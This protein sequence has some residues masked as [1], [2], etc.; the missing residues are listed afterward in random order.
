MSATGTEDESGTVREE[1]T[2]GEDKV[3]KGK[4]SSVLPEITVMS[5]QVHTLS[6]LRSQDTVPSS[7]D[8]FDRSFSTRSSVGESSPFRKFNISLP[9]LSTF[10]VE[11][12]RVWALAFHA[13]LHRFHLDKI[14]SPEAN[15]SED[16][17]ASAAEIKP[18]TQGSDFS[19][20]TLRSVLNLALLQSWS[21]SLLMDNMRLHLALLRHM[22]WRRW[23]R[24]CSR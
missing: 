13:H 4:Q 1:E 20:S 5:H 6:P 21:P 11:Q 24:S 17:S 19:A 15:F 3:A 23:R 2:C 22:S 12:F 9:Q 16:L 18:A 14:L 7:P 8:I 10:T